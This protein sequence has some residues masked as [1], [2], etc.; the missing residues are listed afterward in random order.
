MFTCFRR[1]EQKTDLAS[2]MANRVDADDNKWVWVANC[3]WVQ[4]HIAVER[5]VHSSL[6]MTTQWCNTTGTRR[7]RSQE[8]QECHQWNSTS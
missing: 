8:S 3:C 7:W 1:G 4:D 5:D 6:L 2:T